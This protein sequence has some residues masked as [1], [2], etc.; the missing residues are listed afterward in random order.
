MKARL[1]D[2]PQAR[3]GIVS[4]AVDG[5]WSVIG[6]GSPTGSAYVNVDVFTP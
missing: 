4:A 1:P 5:R 2:L 3:H 6:G